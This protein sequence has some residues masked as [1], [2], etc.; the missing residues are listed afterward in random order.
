MSVLRLVVLVGAAGFGCAID[1]VPPFERPAPRHAI[2]AL[3]D[4]GFVEIE[5]D[6]RSR[7]DPEA[8]GFERLDR[9]EDSLR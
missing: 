9:N 2:P 7:C 1:P 8:S 3:A 5:A 6:I 4:G